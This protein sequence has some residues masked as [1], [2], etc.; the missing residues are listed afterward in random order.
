MNKQLFTID[1]KKIYTFISTQ[2]DEINSLFRFLESK[3]YDKLGI[4]DEF[5]GILGIDNTHR[6]A[7]INRLVSLRDDSLL[8]VFDKLGFDKY[9]VIKSKEL[10]YQ[11]VAKFWMKK[12]QEKIDFINSNALLTPFY[13]AIFEGHFLVGLSMNEWFI[14]W[15]KTIIDDAN[16]RLFNEFN[17]D[18]SKIIEFLK[19]N[20]LLD[21]GHNKEIAER[22]YSALI[23]KN[24]KWDRYSYKEAFSENV[25]TIINNLQI[26]ITNL[27]KENDDIYNQKDE[28]I[29]YLQ[30]IINALNETDCDNLVHKWSDVDRAWM[31]ITTP[32][33]IAH[34]LEY[35]ED[36]YR[37]AVAVEWDIRLSN[38]DMSKNDRVSFIKHMFN[39]IYS[40][41]DADGKHKDIYDFSLKSLDK[42]GLYISTPMMFFGSELN[43]LFSAQVV[44]NDEVVSSEYGKKIFAFSDDILQSVKAK[45]FLKLHK[46]F[47]GQEFLDDERKIIFQ[48][49]KKWHHIYD[50]STIGHEYGHILWCDENTETIMNDDGNFKNIEEF[51][52]TAG[53]LMAFFYNK[54][55]EVKYHKEVL[56]DVVK[57]AISLIGWMEVD[58]VLPYY[59]EGL[60]HLSGLFDSDILRF[61]EH[62]LYIDM[63]DNNYNALKDWYE[64]T[65]ISLA[66]HY[67]QKKNATLW[68][69]QFAI[70]K[71]NIYKPINDKIAVFVDYYYTR[72]KKIGDVLDL[73]D[74]KN[75][76]IKG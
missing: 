60:I 23:Y 59:C 9:R 55:E 63:S 28:Y 30:S 52:A 43:G 39:E 17:G 16:D 27:N 47:L 71:D 37:K 22:S 26:F 45:P 58:E 56:R 29:N 73:E 69:N 8:R 34:P 40:K 1:I 21:L 48:D 62:K 53:G 76:Y 18:N 19:S 68:L 41:V 31:Q 50:I 15:N 51:K 74:S 70:K 13:R 49:E 10:A 36:H 66:K 14:S 67:L 32:I 12:H 57:R 5:A 20:S 64:E 3:Q 44:P 24:S 38:P 65:Y 35:Y 2:K 72:Y 4:I 6:L 25:N 46:E 61:E 54:N 33:Q 75:K 7:L 11:F 42:V